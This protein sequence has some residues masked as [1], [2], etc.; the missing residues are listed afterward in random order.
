MKRNSGV[1][2]L[3]FAN[4]FPLIMWAFLG[5]VCGIILVIDYF[6]SVQF[7]SVQSLRRVQLFA[8]P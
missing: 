6:P 1:L 7:S 8:T 4:T 2:I 5:Y 3:C